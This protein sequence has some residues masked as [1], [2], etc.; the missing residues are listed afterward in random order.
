MYKAYALLLRFRRQAVVLLL[1][2][3]TFAWASCYD[4]PKAAIDASHSDVALALAAA[5]GGY[6][7]VRAQ[8]DPLLGQ[9]WVMVAR[10][11]HPEWPLLEFPG[12]TTSSIE[13]S[14]LRPGSD[15][16]PVVVHAGETVRLWRR[17]S[18]LQ[19]EVA[20]ISEQNGSL[21]KTVRVRLLKGG[22]ESS[23]SPEE[24]TG[25]VKGPADVEMEP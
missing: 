24:F 9:R 7:V 4:T 15:T 8:T 6:K 14:K 10:C 13:P 3:V 2:S 23:S 11:D 21:G 22:S 5:K 19:I 17:E 20:G 16:S 12:E 18:L 1:Q 25:V